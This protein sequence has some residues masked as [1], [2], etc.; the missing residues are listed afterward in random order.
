MHGIIRK[1]L[2]GNSKILWNIA[3]LS[4]LINS[5]GGG[6]DGGDGGGGGDGL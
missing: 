3:I 2:L 6:G 4:S 5:G 1:L